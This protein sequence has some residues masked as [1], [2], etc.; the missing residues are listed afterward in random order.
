MTAKEPSTKVILQQ[1]MYIKSMSFEAHLVYSCL[2]GIL[3]HA[4]I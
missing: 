2:R 3:K 4:F 1:K